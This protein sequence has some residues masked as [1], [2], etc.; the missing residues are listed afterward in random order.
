MAQD[1][2]F[3]ATTVN[4]GNTERVLS[5]L[6]GSLLL[7]KVTQ[8]HKADSLLLLA[9]GYLLYRGLSGHCPIHSLFSRKGADHARNINVRASVIVNKPREEVYAFWRKLE[10]L[11]L[12][13][14]HLESVDEI[15]EYTSAWKARI[16][17]GLGYI[18]WEAEIVNEEEGLVLSWQSVPG[19]SIRNAGKINFSDTPGK[20]TRI[21][22]LISY[23]APMG[24]F[25][26][27]VSHLLSP[28]FSRMVEEDIV[29]FK[30]FIEDTI[31]VKPYTYLQ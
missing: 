13:M 6:A 16:P 17:G 12:F 5:T 22:A 10:N 20:G 23:H 21:D 15:D 30:H 1:T 7:Y 25:G 28:V 27:G 9:G 3:K 11:P 14:K 19:A 26:E 29:G 8:K 24:K 2:S 18:R 31:T 4:T